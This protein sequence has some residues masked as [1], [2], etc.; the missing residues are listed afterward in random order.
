MKLLVFRYSGKRMPSV[1]TCHI[2][3]F[4]LKPGKCTKYGPH[5]MITYFGKK[6]KL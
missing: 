3:G 2:P 4:Q 1:Y 5:Y 6:I